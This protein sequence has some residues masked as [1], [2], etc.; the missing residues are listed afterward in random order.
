MS[1][2]LRTVFLKGS[3]KNPIVKKDEIMF[4]N[5]SKISQYLKSFSVFLTI[6]TLL[7][8]P[9]GIVYADPAS[10]FDTD[11]ARG[12][13]RFREVVNT[14]TD[15]NAV[16]YEKPF[17][18]STSNIFSVN[19]N[20]GSTVWVRATKAGSAVSF[21][22]IQDSN[23]YFHMWSVGV[24]SW[25]E[26]VNE[27][28]KFEF[29]TS[30]ALT[31]PVEVNAFG[32]Y[33]NDWG[34]CCLGPNYTPTGTASGTAIYTIFD[35]GTIGPSIELLGNITSTISSTTHFVAEI[36]DRDETFT[37]VTVA[38]NGD[39]ER[40]GM[41]GYIIFSKVGKDSV[42]PGSGS[43]PSIPPERPDLTAATDLGNSN[44]DNLTSDTT[45]DN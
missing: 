29:F 17:S 34:T 38:P 6:V 39:G 45:P 3:G 30:S 1:T 16:F 23:G 33:V 44:T 9:S 20:D 37:E 15:N 21:D 4:T 25:N 5:K 41:G 36:D 8:I 18:S 19:G 32:V 26:V 27:G 24:S 43:T 42:P 13:S 35:G 7:G 28:V 14:A 10:F 31:T 22:T 12:K 40:F 11:L 2:D